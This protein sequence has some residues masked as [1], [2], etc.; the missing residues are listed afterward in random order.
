MRRR[1]PVANASTGARD[2]LSCCVNNTACVAACGGD[3]VVYSTLD[4]IVVWGHDEML[5]MNQTR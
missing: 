1:I 4:E 2:A 5:I 3:T